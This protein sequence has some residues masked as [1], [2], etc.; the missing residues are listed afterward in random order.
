MVLIHY[1]KNI[2][3][4]GNLYIF[5]LITSSDISGTK[6]RDHDTEHIMMLPIKTITVLNNVS[7][8]IITSITACPI[9]LPVIRTIIYIFTSLTAIIY[10]ITAILKVQTDII[11]NFSASQIGRARIF[12]I[13]SVEAFRTDVIVFISDVIMCFMSDWPITC[14]CELRSDL[15]FLWIKVSSVIQTLSAVPIKGKMSNCPIIYIIILYA[16]FFNNPVFL[17]D[18]RHALISHN[19]YMLHPYLATCYN[20]D[21]YPT[22]T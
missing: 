1:L 9:G 12:V 8:Y 16:N 3:S 21:V 4:I 11:A 17:L 22:H 19:F 14:A 7:T 5:T 18:R 6:E 10:R 20:F 2:C 13:M 15:I